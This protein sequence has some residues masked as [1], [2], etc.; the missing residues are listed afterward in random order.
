[1]EDEL[2]DLEADLLLKEQNLATSIEEDRFALM[3]LRQSL[4]YTE[5]DLR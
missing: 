5:E 2:D 4:K 3:K 1:L